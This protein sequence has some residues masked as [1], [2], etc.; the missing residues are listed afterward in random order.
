MLLYARFGMTHWTK[1]AVL[2]GG[3]GRPMVTCTLATGSRTR[4]AV[5]G[6]LNKVASSLCQKKMLGLRLISLAKLSVLYLNSSWSDFRG[7][8]NVFLIF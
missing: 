2:H 8:R 5:R 3:F 6:C 7:I 1:T 4:L